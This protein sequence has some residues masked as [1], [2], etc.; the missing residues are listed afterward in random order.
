MTSAGPRAAV[1]PARSSAPPASLFGALDVRLQTAVSQ[2]RAAAPEPTTDALRGLYISDGEVDALLADA[3]SAAPAAPTRP[4]GRVG[5]VAAQLH[6]LIQTYALDPLDADV[7]LICLAPEIDRRYERLYGYLQDDLTRRR[8]TIDLVLL[9]LEYDS[10]LIRRALGP[11][12]HLAK[13]NLL[14]D[15]TD[16]GTEPTSF[17]STTLRLHPR[18]SEY[19]LGL[20]HLDPALESWAR[21]EAPASDLV[22][23]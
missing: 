5:D 10:P 23:V 20:D 14:A 17:L 8:P 18:I 12:G 19:L 6:R 2:F 16:A 21:F 15:T 22:A 11:D 4:E 1:G 13:R 3:D 9:L 7:L